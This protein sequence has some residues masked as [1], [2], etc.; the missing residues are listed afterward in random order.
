[1]IQTVIF[2]AT[3]VFVVSGRCP[4]V[5]KMLQSVFFDNEK[6]SICLTG[7]LTWRSHLWDSVCGERWRVA[8]IQDLQA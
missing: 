2:M 3:Y 4:A 1:M 5:E 6:F 8:K 7:A